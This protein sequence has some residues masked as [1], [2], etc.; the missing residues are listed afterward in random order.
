MWKIK[1]IDQN[2][3]SNYNNNFTYSSRYSVN[4]RTGVQPMIETRCGVGLYSD[5]SGTSSAVLPLVD[6]IIA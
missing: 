5:S 6:F 1:H 2:F 3:H 4:G